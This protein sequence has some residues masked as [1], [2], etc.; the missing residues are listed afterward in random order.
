MMLWHSFLEFC[1]IKSLNVCQNVASTANAIVKIDFYFI[2][3]RIFP[4]K[5]YFV[6][7]IALSLKVHNCTSVAHVL[8]TF[9]FA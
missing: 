4:K 5:K 9:P 8:I 1:C 7:L 2:S 3:S 6:I